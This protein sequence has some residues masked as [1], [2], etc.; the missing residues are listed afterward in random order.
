MEKN[1]RCEFTEQG[2]KNDS[3]Q[4][5]QNRLRKRSEKERIQGNK[6]RSKIVPSSPNSISS[7]QTIPKI[8][9]T[10]ESLLVQSN[11]VQIISLPNLLHTSTSNGLNQ[12]KER[13]KH[14]NLE[15]RRR[16]APPTLEQRKIARINFDKY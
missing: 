8:R 14:K 11:M 15:I 7:A 5:K 16:F 3:F 6:S 2:D 4:N 10:I 12:E 1:S 9:S 13:V